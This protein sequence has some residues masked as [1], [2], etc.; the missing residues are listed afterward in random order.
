MKRAVIC[1]TNDLSSDQRVQRS[2]SVLQAEGY[3]CCFVGRRLPE[4]KDFKPGYETRRF[5][6]WFR[7]GFAFY[8]AY[9][10]RLFFFLLSRPFEL[11]FSNDLDTLWPTYLVAAWRKKPLIYDSHEYF[12]GVP[13]IQNRPLVKA[14]W[15]SLEA[16]L[17]PRLRHVLTVNESIARLYEQDYGRR[18]RVLRNIASAEIPPALSRSELGLAEEAFLIIN[19]GSGINVDRGMEEM[20]AAL[21]LCPPQVHLLLVGRGDVLPALRQKARAL[22]LEERV[23]FVPPQPY[24]RLLAYTQA[25][26]LG[27]SLDKD[28]NINYRYSLPNKLFD[29]IKCALPVLCSP[30]PE[31]AGIV[32]R[33]QIG[34][35][36]EVEPL[37]LAEAIG[38]FLGEDRNRY[39][40]GLR[41]A[42]AE[43]HW[44]QEKERLREI[45][46]EAE[47]Q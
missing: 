27:I 28:T 47:A 15:K 41:R 25:A 35:V 23:I 8:A 13:E 9:N 33:Y 2:I 29:Y 43:N 7:R 16:Y 46:A 20:L 18:P 40:A 38:E 32:R 24:R 36:A 37:A 31:V 10:M 17:F 5:R 26:D 6:L 14:V 1:V 19:Q 30:V 21:P 4:S 22:G 12:T 42:A 39:R 11:Y 34:R 3:Q 44:E 45:L